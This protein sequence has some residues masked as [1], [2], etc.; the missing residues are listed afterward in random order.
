MD[1]MHGIGMIAHMPDAVR[2][3]NPSPAAMPVTTPPRVM[4]RRPGGDAGRRTIWRSVRRRLAR[5]SRRS[6][7]SSSRA[8]RGSV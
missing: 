8:P 7:A 6:D 4:L 2:R 1:A 5:I 3:G